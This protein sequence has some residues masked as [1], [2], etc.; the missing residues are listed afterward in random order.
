LGGVEVNLGA[1]DQ[2]V[3]LNGSS[4]AAV[5]SGFENVN[6]SAFTGF[7]AVVT[8]S[9]GANTITGTAVADQITGGSGADTITGGAGNDTIDLTETTASSD[10]VIYAASS[11]GEDQITGFTVGATG[12]D[13]LNFTAVTFANTTVEGAKKGTLANFDAVTEIQ[14]T[15]VHG[16]II[17]TD[18]NL[19][20]SAAIT[21]AMNLTDVDTT[22][23]TNFL[24]IWEDS[25]DDGGTVHVGIINS[26]A[27]TND[28]A[29]VTYTQVVRLVGVADTTGFVAANVDA[30]A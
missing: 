22:A 29:S 4:N 6:L 2:V 5:Q 10:I 28:D 18:T 17:L 20:A 30:I 8:G 13:V 14:A 23:N 27:G 26:G 9:S 7:G 12:G 15:A 25:D 3:S 21:T 11:N 16:V 19:T 1:T 24:V